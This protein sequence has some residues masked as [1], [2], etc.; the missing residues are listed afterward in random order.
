MFIDRAIMILD[1]KLSQ[2]FPFSIHLLSVGN[3]R[4]LKEV[5]SQTILHRNLH[6]FFLQFYSKNQFENS[7]HE[8]SLTLYRVFHSFLIFSL[9]YFDKLSVVVNCHHNGRNFQY[10]ICLKLAN[11]YSNWSLET[12]IQ[13]SCV[14]IIII[15]Q[16]MSIQAFDLET[17]SI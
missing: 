15:A 17:R 11:K 9:L 1:T 12:E 8:R 7:R 16:S 10:W 5:T 2:I 4:S 13:L 6:R 14:S 3:F